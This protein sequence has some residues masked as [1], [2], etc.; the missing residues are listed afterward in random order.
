MGECRQEIKVMGPRLFVVSKFLMHLLIYQLFSSWVIW[1]RS[2][3]C[4][5]MD[6]VFLCVNY[7]QVAVWKFCQLNI[8]WSLE[9]VVY[10][11]WAWRSIF[12]ILKKKKKQFY[13]WIVNR[14]FKKV[15]IDRQGFFFSVNC[16]QIDV[17]KFFQLNI[18]HEVL[19][20]LCIDIGLEA[21]FF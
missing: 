17:W 19:N 6:K 9:H 14:V 10:W 20:M 18:L 8:V 2:C 15:V 3:L 11:Y 21:Q 5:K 13:V 4:V 1:A 12:L 16:E 7:E